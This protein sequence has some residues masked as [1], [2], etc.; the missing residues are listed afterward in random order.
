MKQTQTNHKVLTII[1][2]EFH[3]AQSVIKYALYDL[4]VLLLPTSILRVTNKRLFMF[5]LL[6]GFFPSC[7]YYL[8]V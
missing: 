6:K 4:T 1:S 3:I 2:I 7:M 8:G 5:I